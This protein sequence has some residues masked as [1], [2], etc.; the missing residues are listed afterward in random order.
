MNHSGAE[1]RICKIGIFWNVDGEL[2]C[3][4]VPLVNAPMTNGI[5]D[6]EADHHSFWNRWTRKRINFRAYSYDHYPRGRIIFRE[7]DQKFVIYGDRC[8]ISD[9]SFVS[10]LQDAFEIP[11]EQCEVWG[12]FHYQCQKCNPDFISDF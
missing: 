8:L 4:T 3:E 11:H 12:D 6:I 7:T 10:R 1:S 9:P 5:R 2:V